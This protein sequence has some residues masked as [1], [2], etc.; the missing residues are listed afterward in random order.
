LGGL[1]LIQFLGPSSI[2]YKIIYESEYSLR[3][4]KEITANFKLIKADKTT[5]INKL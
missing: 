3:M 2:K 5:D 4:R 1:K